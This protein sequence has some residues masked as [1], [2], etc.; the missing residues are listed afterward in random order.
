M[1]CAFRLSGEDRIL[2]G[3]TNGSLVAWDGAFELCTVFR[4]Q[5]HFSANAIS[6]SP[7][8]GQLLV[9]SGQWASSPQAGCL[10]VLDLPDF[11]VV[12]RIN[13]DDRIVLDLAGNGTRKRLVNP[14]GVQVNGIVPRPNSHE[15]AVAFHHGEVSLY[16][17]DRGQWR[18]V[19]HTPSQSVYG[20]VCTQSGDRLIYTGSASQLVDFDLRTWSIR[21]RLD[22]RVELTALAFA[23]DQDLLVVGDTRGMLYIVRASDLRSGRVFSCGGG[24]LRPKHLLRSARRAIRRRRARNPPLQPSRRQQP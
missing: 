20:L 6:E 11:R 22:L 9:G 15:V 14:H 17:L 1:C 21:R 7:V 2:L 5:G 10:Y 13:L 4:G 3:L 19:S 23:A 8:E 18:R 16:D 12:D 24:R